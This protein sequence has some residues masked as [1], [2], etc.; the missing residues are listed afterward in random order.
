MPP[1]ALPSHSHRAIHTAIH[2]A[3]WRSDA[4]EQL[5]G[6][7]GGAWEVLERYC[8]GAQEVLGG[9]QWGLKGHSGGTRR[10]T[11]SP[12]GT[13]EV[14]RRYSE[15][16]LQYSRGHRRRRPTCL[17]SSSQPFHVW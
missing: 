6:D 7:S 10:V 14:L 9:S 8:L 17:S 2:T 1:R 12:G 16:V 5:R 4:M 13:Q 15:A 11:R 3:E